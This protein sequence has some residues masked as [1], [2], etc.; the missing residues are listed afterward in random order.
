M[1]RRFVYILPRGG[2]GAPEIAAHCETVFVVMPQTR[3]SFV[4]TVDFVTTF[5][6]GAGGDERERLG[7]GT[8]GP[9]TVITDLC[10]MRPDPRT[11][12]LCVASLHPGVSEDHVRDHTGW[13]IH[14][15]DDVEETAAPT[16]WE[17]QV[18]RDLKHRSSEVPR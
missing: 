10:L 7:L 15:P 14:I 16:P 3:R 18:L 2:G 17:L 1:R 6:F 13:P 9:Q 11:R 12:E 5:G 8:Q 4:H